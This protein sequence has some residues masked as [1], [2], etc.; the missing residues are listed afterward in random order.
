MPGGTGHTRPRNVSTGMRDGTSFAPS[1]T[2]RHLSSAFLQS[3]TMAQGATPQGMCKRLPAAPGPRW[4]SITGGPGPDHQQPKRPWEPLA[5]KICAS[6]SRRSMSSSA[7]STSRAWEPTRTKLGRRSSARQ[8][9]F[10]QGHDA[11]LLTD[12]TSSTWT[13]P[14]VHYTE[15]QAELRGGRCPISVDPFGN[16]AVLLF[17]TSRCR[18]ECARPRDYRQNVQQGCMLPN[19]P[20]P[21]AP[22]YVPRE[23]GHPA[24]PNKNRHTRVEGNCQ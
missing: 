8:G 3:R 11:T 14:S 13:P 16:T 22:L 1:E 17:G 10:D 21:R 20:P 4:S 15:D 18:W 24:R 23:R 19:S 7:T 12:C 9:T 2:S 6:A 5:S